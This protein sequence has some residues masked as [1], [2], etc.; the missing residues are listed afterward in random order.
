[1]EFALSLSDGRKI[2]LFDDGND[3]KM[4]V[5]AQTRNIRAIKVAGDYH[6]S[7]TVI[8]HEDEIY[9]AY[10]S[11]ARELSV[12]TIM[13]EGRFVLFQD[14][15]DMFDIR[16]LKLYIMNEKLYLFCMLDDA[17]GNLSIRAY[18]V[19][20]N[21]KGQNIIS[22]AMTGY[23][24][25]RAGNYNML[26]CTYE[27]GVCE[28]Y[29][30]TVINDKIQRKKLYIECEENVTKMIEKITEQQDGKIQDIRN[31]YEINLKKELEKQQ[32]IF[33]Q[34]YEKLSS[35]AREIQ[36]EGKYWRELYY[37]NVNK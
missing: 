28:Y 23:K 35:A 6:S 5:A 24:I 37:K 32:E 29:A 25:L 10:L 33:K 14:V 18:D 16:Q 15:G 22:G 8:K 17:D 26:C 19:N 34:R 21:K 27:S 11:Y 1:M 2:L 9:A 13:N 30:M 7:M 3:I 4:L 36:E 31:E 12:L 20:G